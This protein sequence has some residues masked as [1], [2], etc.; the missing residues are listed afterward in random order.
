MQKNSKSL[1]G[2]K[3]LI[4]GGGSDMVS[5]TELAHCLGC[6]VYITD[7]YDTL[8]SPAKLVADEAA[9][10]SI[11]DTDAIVAYIR[12]KGIDGVITGYTDSYLEQYLKI[13]RA[14]DLPCYGTERAFGVAA[15]TNLF[16]T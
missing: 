4:L 12:K 16:A 7:Y 6:K 8:R 14:A 5:V 11:F 2:K 10:I 13:C 15:D 9:D 3:L 1:E